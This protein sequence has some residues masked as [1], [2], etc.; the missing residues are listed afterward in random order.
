MGTSV[1]EVIK[2]EHFDI[3]VRKVTIGNCIRSMKEIGRINFL[4]IFENINGVEEVLKKD[5]ANVYEKMDYQ[6]KAYYRNKIKEI[7]KKT[8]ISEIY[9]TKKALELAK[10]QEKKTSK[11]A[12]IGYYLIDQGEKELYQLLQTNKKPHMIKNS[13]ANSGTLMK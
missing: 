5:P 2:K 9:I 13:D 3:A 4:E 8:K 10:K 11:K 12:H 7:S 6:T 1:T